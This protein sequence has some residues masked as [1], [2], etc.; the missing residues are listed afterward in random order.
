MSHPHKAHRG[1]P[2][3]RKRRAQPRANWR[4]VGC[5][6]RG[7]GR[8]CGARAIEANC[9]RSTKSAD[10]RSMR[11]PRRSSSASC[12]RS[13][14]I[15]SARNSWLRRGAAPQRDDTG[16]ERRRR[17]VAVATSLVQEASARKPLGCAGSVGPVP[18]CKVVECFVQCIRSLNS[19][20]D[21][22]IP[23]VR[24]GDRVSRRYIGSTVASRLDAESG[25]PSRH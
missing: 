12:A 21:P 2:A 9:G 3:F 4:S 8:R 5:S 24:L 19:P 10:S 23:T 7:S 16:C 17:A 22:I 15:R 25:V 6:I 14:P 18:L 11:R 13:S 1:A 20:D